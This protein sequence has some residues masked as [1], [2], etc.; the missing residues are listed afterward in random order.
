MFP[1]LLVSPDDSMKMLFVLI[2]AGVFV[3]LARLASRSSSNSSPGESIS[4]SDQPSEQP[5]LTWGP[6]AEEV[7][8]PFPAD[9]L[10][11][12]IRIQKFYFAQTEASPGPTDPEVFADELFVE[13]HDPDTG[14]DW[15]QSYFVV[16]PKGLANLLAEKHW[17]YVHAPEMLGVPRYDLE[18]I[19]RAVV[20]RVVA[21][22]E[23]YK[24][25]K[26][27]EQVEEESLD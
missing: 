20:S 7:A 18:E 3:L 5:D 9:P 15:W 17:K 13:L 19:R 22:H 25:L 21:E 11:G 10:L 24:G 1:V 26:E 6:S 8:A 23:Y 12:K 4:D 16:T 14:H 2:I 27:K